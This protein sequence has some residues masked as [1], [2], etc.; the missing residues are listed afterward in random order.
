MKLT[1]RKY[2]KRSHKHK[3]NGKC[4]SLR[5]NISRMKKRKSKKQ[6]RKKRFNKNLSVKKKGG[7]IDINDKIDIDGTKYTINEKGKLVKEVK[8]LLLER[9][10]LVD[11][12]ELVEKVIQINTPKGLIFASDVHVK[13]MTRVPGTPFFVDKTNIYKLEVSADKKTPIFKNCEF[14]YYCI[15]ELSEIKSKKKVCFIPIK[16]EVELD[17]GE[18]EMVSQEDR[19]RGNNI[20]NFFKLINPEYKSTEESAIF[21]HGKGITWSKL[22]NGF[23]KIREQT[24]S[25]NT[26]IIGSHHA[27]LRDWLFDF[28][29]R[30]TEMK[31]TYS[32]S[33]RGIDNCC[34]IH[35]KFTKNE[36]DCLVT[37][38]KVLYSKEIFFEDLMNKILEI[39]KK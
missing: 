15:P 26:F 8:G 29:D 5:N 25:A 1:L 6:K 33:K 2:K 18:N 20:I 38:V 11:K 30:D 37:E 17:L 7:E 27:L 3:R 31:N 39:K 16:S 35:V 19:K 4:K 23:T 22:L 36:K 21:K 34:C 10:K 24:E 14:H 32:K 28:G 12:V 13:N 9:N